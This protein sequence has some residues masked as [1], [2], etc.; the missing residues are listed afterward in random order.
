[1]KLGS[2]FLYLSDYYILYESIFDEEMLLEPVREE[3]EA[4]EKK[5]CERSGVEPPS[6]KS[7]LLEVP[8]KSSGET[9]VESNDIVT[10]SVDHNN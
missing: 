4:K 10:K 3:Y 5:S 9:E 8:I 6:P 2:R 7:F 1:M